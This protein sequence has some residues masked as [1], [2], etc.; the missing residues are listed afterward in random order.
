MAGGALHFLGVGGYRTGF[1]GV[2]VPLAALT[3]PVSW[4]GLRGRTDRVLWTIA[5]V[6]VAASVAGVLTSAAPPSRDVL[7]AE[8]RKLLP[9]FYEEVSNESSGHSWCRPSCPAVSVVATPPATGDPAVMIE[10]ASGLFRRGL[11][12]PEDLSAVMRRRS[13]E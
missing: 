10:V 2:F 4:F 6:V 3:G 13:F 7:L 11:L 5:L 8:A 9:P 1:L 12:S